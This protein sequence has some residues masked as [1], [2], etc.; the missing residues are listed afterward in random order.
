MLFDLE[1]LYL[2]S[3]NIIGIFLFGFSIIIMIFFSRK[4]YIILKNMISSVFNER[5]TQYEKMN[6]KKDINN[7]NKGKRR[8]TQRKSSSTNYTSNILKS[9]NVQNQNKNKNLI[10]SNPRKKIN[11]KYNKE[12][13]NKIANIKSKVLKDLNKQNIQKEISKTKTQ[14][15]SNESRNIINK[16]FNT[17]AKK[18]I[19]IP[20]IELDFQ[21]F[22][23]SELNLLSYEK[24]LKYD[25][26]NYIQYYISLLK[27]KH[28]LFFSFC[29]T[30]DYNSTLLKI[31]IFFFTFDINFS[32]NVMFY[33]E[34]QINKIYQDDSF[35]FIYQIPHMIYSSLISI[36]LINL[37]KK[38]GLFEDNIL[39]IKNCEYGQIKKTLE[40]EI[41]CIKI[42]V[43]LFFVITYVIL[44]A[45]WIYVGCFFS[46]YKYTQIHLIKEVSSSFGMSLLTPL[47]ISLLPGI[48][49]IPSLKN[50]K[51]KESLLYKFS[52]YL[53]L[54]C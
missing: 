3:A 39:N 17:I 19:L 4:N 10:K 21:E 18:S 34:S 11:F 49:R 29:N 43:I 2:N 26:R 22:I 15:G 7:N 47:V 16:K 48:L 6:T 8:E 46:V 28:I 51:S 13:N 40:K 54:L 41:K 53:Q 25:K 44:F 50:K 5:K 23:D 9:M 36:V 32:V 31:Y 14:V 12:K 27:T 42:K 52:K 38:L 24:A 37:I 33:T 30:K 35:D 1:N 20:N 45:F